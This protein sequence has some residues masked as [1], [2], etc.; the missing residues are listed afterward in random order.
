MTLKQSAPAGFMIFVSFLL[1]LSLLQCRDTPAGTG[2]RKNDEKTVDDRTVTFSLMPG[3]WHGAFCSFPF[4]GLCVLCLA[5]HSTVV[6]PARPGLHG[7]WKP[8][9]GLTSIGKVILCLLSI[10]VFLWLN[11][12][13]TGVSRFRRRKMGKQ[14]FLFTRPCV[15]LLPGT[16]V[17]TMWNPLL[18]KNHTIFVGLKFA[19]TLWLFVKESFLMRE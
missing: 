16:G 5:Q 8:T 19:T 15:C 1:S 14:G 10:R 7:G 12:I 2:E 17:N 11:V 18:S 4:F 6:C 9:S 13:E 3:G